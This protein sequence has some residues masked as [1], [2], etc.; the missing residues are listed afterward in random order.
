MTEAVLNTS[1]Q[2]NHLA[3]SAGKEAILKTLAYFDIFQY[4]L[5][6]G[7]IRLFSAEYFSENELREQLMELERRQLVFCVSGYYLLQ[8]D[9]SFCQRRKAGNERAEQLLVKAEK[10]GRF[11]YQFP[12]VKAVGVS[13][14]LS[15]N[16]A[17]DK[18]DIDF[19]I[20]TRSNRLWIARTF[21]H[22]FKKFTFLTGRQH[23]YCMN[24]Y[25][26]EM[27]L[28]LDDKNI[29]AATEIKT[30]LPVCGQET[31][32]E[33]FLHNSW[34]NDYLPACAFRQQGEKDPVRS[35]FKRTGEWLLANK[36]GNGLEK[37]FMRIT[38]K[39][40][41]KKEDKGKRNEKGLPMGLISGKHF[42][43]SNPG[44]LQEKV[45]ITYRQRVDELVRKLSMASGV[46]LPL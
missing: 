10:I 23:Y 2:V 3:G 43:R 17:D 46:L 31:M 20:I 30:L 13:G 7:E 6:F 14:S 11:L 21:M 39:R 37:L 40:W 42:A 27:A 22:L 44:G 35:L 9:P 1:A 4:P 18:A 26:D 15:K 5:T 41:N 33:F 12:F 32:N 19:F 45:L 8:N 36:A 38:Q 28:K 29:F 16:F 25:I 34:A 24:Y